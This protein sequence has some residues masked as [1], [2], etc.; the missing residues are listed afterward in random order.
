MSSPQDTLQKERLRLNGRPVRFPTRLTGEATSPATGGEVARADQ[1]E[2]PMLAGNWHMGREPL[3]GAEADEKLPVV[4]LHSFGGN[5]QEYNGLFL[6]LTAELSWRN[7]AAL[8][9][10]FLGCGASDGNSDA[11]TPSQMVQDTGAALSEVARL[12]GKNRAH[13]VGYSLGGLIAVLSLEAFADQI[14]SLSLLQAPYN[15]ESEL[16]RRYPMGFDGVRTSAYI[17]A[18]IFRPSQAFK[19]ELSQLGKAPARV[20]AKAAP[21]QVFLVGGGNDAIVP[22]QL[23]QAAWQDLF[24]SH[25]YQT[26]CLSLPSADHGFSLEEDVFTCISSLCEFLSQASAN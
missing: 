11:I 8:R 15:L 7:F 9:F 4:L 2:S 1:T 10:D 3:A 18:P 20:V 26:R 16:K 17:N 21:R 5:K 13:L 23:N 24:Q 25:N 19:V 22:E 12:S 14:A 6:R